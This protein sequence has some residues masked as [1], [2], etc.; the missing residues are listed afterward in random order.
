VP[1][2]LLSLCPAVLPSKA[3]D[4]AATLAAMTQQSST[5]LVATPEQVTAL[6][7][8]LAEDAAKPEAKRK[9]DLSSLR[10]GLVGVDGGAT[11]PSSLGK[12]ALRPVRLSKLPGSAAF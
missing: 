11:A 8:A 10:S 7:A 1:V 5:A 12:A 2:A 9:Y 4:A 6:A 3:F